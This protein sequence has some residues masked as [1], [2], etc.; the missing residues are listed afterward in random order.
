MAD[1]MNQV[2]DTARLVANAR[3]SLD[4]A[5]SALVAALPEE[6]RS[7][8][9]EADVAGF[10]FRAPSLGAGTGFGGIPKLGRL[11]GV[12]GADAGLNIACDGACSPPAGFSTRSI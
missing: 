7:E 2:L 8:F 1:D 5:L 10:A 9:G 11:G 4:A 3:A 6:A 12:G